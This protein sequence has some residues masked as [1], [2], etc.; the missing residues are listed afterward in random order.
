M[1]EVV[2]S[3]HECTDERASQFVLNVLSILSATFFNEGKL[4]GRETAAV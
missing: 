2:K 3:P 1:T 4:I